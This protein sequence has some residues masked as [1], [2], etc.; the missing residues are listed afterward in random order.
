MEDL[1]RAIETYPQRVAEVTGRL[2]EAAARTV[3]GEVA[4]GRI[5]VT[6]NG[7]GEISEVRLSTSALRDLDAGSLTAYV[8]EATNSA[9]DQAD[10]LLA[11]AGATGQ[12]D[13]MDA[14]MDR[15][16]RRMDDVLGDLDRISASLDRLRD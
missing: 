5:A 16:T 11:A 10:E 8:I 12:P 4:E 3:T 15:F 9:L 2:T 1:R 14:A 13:D 6:A 7:R